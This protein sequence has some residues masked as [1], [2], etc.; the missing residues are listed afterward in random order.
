MPMFLVYVLHDIDITTML[1]WYPVTL[2][3]RLYAAAILVAAV[4]ICMCC[5]S[6]VSSR[7]LANQCFVYQLLEA[8]YGS[9]GSH[10]LGNKTGL[11]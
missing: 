7:L 4:T 11:I 5:I 9:G 3:Y 1:Y 10:S 8:V 6:S 2:I